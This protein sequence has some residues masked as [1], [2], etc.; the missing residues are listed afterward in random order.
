M[1]SA[2]SAGPGGELGLELGVL[3]LESLEFGFL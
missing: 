3:S 1:S 2:W